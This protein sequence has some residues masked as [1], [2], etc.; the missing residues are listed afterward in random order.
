M[1]GGYGLG[2]GLGAAGAG[3]AQGQL[4]AKILAPQL[5]SENLQNQ[6]KGQAVQEGQMNIAQRQAENQAYGTQ[7]QVQGDSLTPYDQELADLKAAHDNVPTGQGVVRQKIQQQAVDLGMKRHT[8]LI[9]AGVQ[10]ALAQDSANAVKYLKAA[11]TPAESI[12]MN[13]NGNYEMKLKGQNG[14]IELNPKS[15]YA[16]TQNPAMMDQF[17]QKLMQ[18]DYLLNQLGFKREVATSKQ[19][20][21][22]RK[23]D[24]QHQDRQSQIDA[25]IQNMR[26]RAGA[27]MGVAQTNQ[28]GANF[29]QGQLPAQQFQAFAQTPVEQG[30]LGFT[31]EQTNTWLNTVQQNRKAGKSDDETALSLAIRA[32]AGVPLDPEQL[33]EHA[34]AIKAILPAR[35]PA[36][37]PTKRT[38]VPASATPG[39]GIPP[40]PPGFQVK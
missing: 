40:P 15:L 16:M 8:Y 37:A 4:Q 20:E 11:G 29:R 33:K 22:V 13:E 23:T 3:L 26:T 34:A 5:Q 38:A 1:A 27:M 10:A 24:L 9:G 2:Y 14:P 17:S 36:A 7:G 28:A 12:K 18:N 31:P 39:N 21:S 30:G 19:A 35:A 32:N 6:L 25:S